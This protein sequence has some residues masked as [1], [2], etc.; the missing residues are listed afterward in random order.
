MRLKNKVKGQGA[1]EYLLMLAAVLIIVAV[2]IYYVTRAGGY[3]VVA[4][5]AA[6]YE[7]MVRLNVE[8]GEIAAYEWE[9]SV[10]N[11]QGVY[12]WVTGN[13]ALRA[14]WVDLGPYAAGT[15]YVSLRHKGSGHIYF[16]DRAITI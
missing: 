5:T 7:N 3:P 8:T 16:A 11:T 1:T 15:W 6:K 13:T 10:S 12:S 2:A 4:V 9:Y 14:P